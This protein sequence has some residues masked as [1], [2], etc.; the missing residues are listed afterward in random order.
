LIVAAYAAEKGS[1]QFVTAFA[2]ADG[3]RRWHVALPD[4]AERVSK[5]VTSANR[6]FIQTREQLLLLDATD[7]KLLA[8]IGKAS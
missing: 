6:V 7:G 1:R 4:G 8:V 2:L 5:L 3:E